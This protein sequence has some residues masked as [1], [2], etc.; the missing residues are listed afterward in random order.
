MN[1]GHK[2]QKSFKENGIKNTYTQNQKQTD[3]IEERG[4][5]ELTLTS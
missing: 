4:H 1:G 2:Q 5:G 3:G